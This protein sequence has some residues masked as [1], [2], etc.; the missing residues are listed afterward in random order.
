[1]QKLRNLLSELAEE[2]ILI[3]SNSNFYQIKVQDL[4]TLFPLLDSNDS[5]QA[6]EYIKKLVGLADTNFSIIIGLEKV[7]QHILE[8]LFNPKCFGYINDSIEYK[9]VNENNSRYYVYKVTHENKKSIIENIG[10]FTYRTY[11][12]S[13]IDFK[14]KTAS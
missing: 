9:L 3:K 14:S 12:L 4:I 8:K 1:M 13:Y 2:P 10:T 11:A 5:Q 6:I 7:G